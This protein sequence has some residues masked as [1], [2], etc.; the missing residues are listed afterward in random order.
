MVNYS[1]VNFGDSRHCS[2]GNMILICRVISREQIFKGL[3]DFMGRN[4]SRQVITVT[5]LV[6]IGLVPV[7]I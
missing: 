4:T 7:E 5:H 2:S 6:S 3:C 1:S